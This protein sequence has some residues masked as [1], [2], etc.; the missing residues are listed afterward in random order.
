MPSPAT[1]PGWRMEPSRTLYV[2]ESLYVIY[3]I[4]WIIYIYIYIYIY[5]QCKLQRV[6]TS[7]GT[8]RNRMQQP[9]AAQTLTRA[10]PYT[11]WIWLLHPAPTSAHNVFVCLLAIC[12]CHLFVTGHVKKEKVLFMN[13]GKIWAKWTSEL[14][15]DNNNNKCTAVCS[16][17]I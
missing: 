15:T 12:Q 6:K 13:G 14:N 8:S 7:L 10:C 1:Y 9:I 4:L 5:L 16:S 17:V 11:T 3:Y 2:S